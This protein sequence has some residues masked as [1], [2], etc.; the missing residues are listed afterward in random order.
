MERIVPLC[1][2]HMLRSSRPRMGSIALHGNRIYAQIL[3]HN[4]ILGFWADRE[5]FSGVDFCARILRNESRWP[6]GLH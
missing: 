2:I 1:M 4:P 5:L 6:H 3:T